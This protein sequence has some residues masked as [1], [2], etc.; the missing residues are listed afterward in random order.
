MNKKT[1]TTVFIMCCTLLA[2]A[3]SRTE[4]AKINTDDSW[5][6]VKSAI[7]N[8]EVESV[9]QAHSLDVSVSLK[10]GETING[11]EPNIDDILDL[12]QDAKE[13]CGEIIMGTE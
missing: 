10:N 11:V 2:S 6:Q 7:A 4:E 12:A 8:C 13:K 1:L 5:E 3:C 9:F